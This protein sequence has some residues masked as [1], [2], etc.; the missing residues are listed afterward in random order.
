M[1][2]YR[3]EPRARLEMIEQY[4]TSE[5]FV[6]ALEDRFADDTWSPELR[7]AVAHA[8]ADG[9]MAG[10]DDAGLVARLLMTRDGPKSPNPSTRDLARIGSAAQLLPNGP[11]V[12]KLRRDMRSAL[13]AYGSNA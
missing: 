5:E 13:D 2:S 11:T 6:A 9:D 1:R 10:E 4:R 7:R 12:A 3:G 8:I